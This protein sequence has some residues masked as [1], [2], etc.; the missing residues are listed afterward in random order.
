MLFPCRPQSHERAV[1]LARQALRMR[2]YA[3]R[4]ADTTFSLGVVD[5]TSPGDVT[6]TLAAWR[7]ATAANVAAGSP[8]H[9]PFG[10]AGLT[11]NPESGLIR[12]DGRLPD[13]RPVSLRA[14]FFVKGLRLYQ[15]SVI[16]KV[17][18]DNASETFFEGIR[19][20]P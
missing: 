7:Q 11:P 13:G 8:E 6:P 9:Q 5:V 12:H 20:A 4:A 1:S 10:A 18:T 2:M 16:G 3:C 14:A 19:S 17:V 15:A